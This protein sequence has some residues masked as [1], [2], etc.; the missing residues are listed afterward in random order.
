MSGMLCNFEAEVDT[1]LVEPVPFATLCVTLNKQAHIE[2]VMQAADWKSCHH[3]ATSREQWVELEHRRALEKAALREAA[4][5][6]E[7]DVAQPKIRDLQQ[8][9]FGLKSERNRGTNESQDAKLPGL[10]N[11]GKVLYMPNSV[12]DSHNM[13]V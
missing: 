13:D 10:M 5:R 3:R 7:L 12:P 4:L 9:V 6:S 8:R 2:L 11:S 1:V